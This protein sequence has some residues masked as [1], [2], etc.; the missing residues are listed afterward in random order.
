MTASKR[1][2]QGTFLGVLDIIGLVL[3][4][5]MSIFLLIALVGGGAM[6]SQMMESNAEMAAL[7]MASLF[8]TMG[9]IILVPVL[10]IFILGLF[11]TIGIFKGQKWSIIVSIIFTV[12][13][14]LS[15]F[16]NMGDINFSMLLINAFVLYLE[17]M[18]LKDPFYNK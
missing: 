11:I 9:A 17:I 16:S 4:G 18:C 12:L 13:G 1:P 5:L 2:W 8:G 15:V 6:I 3:M 10:A 7:P 14:I